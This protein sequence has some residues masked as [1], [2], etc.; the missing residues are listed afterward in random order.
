LDRDK[1][2]I[3][4][5]IWCDY[6]IRY[7]EL[8]TGIGAVCDMLSIDFDPMNLMKLKSEFRP[9]N[10]HLRDYYDPDTRKIVQEV[11]DIELRE[12]GYELV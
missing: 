9:L 8:E 10:R 5:Q 1:Y 11:F 12:F 4:G 6:L 3:N 7:E 2:L